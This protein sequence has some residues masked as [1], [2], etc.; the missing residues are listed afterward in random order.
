MLHN[1]YI[2]FNVI[3]T[4]NCKTMGIVD[5]SY[6]NP[7]M[8]VTGYT[9]QVLVPGYDDAV[10]LSYYPSAVTILNSNLLGITKVYDYDD[11]LDLPDGVYT[12]KLSI[13]PYD[14]FWKETSFYRTCKLECKYSQALLSLDFSNC[15]DCFSTSKVNKLKEAKIF[16]EGVKANMTDC[17]FKKATELYQKADSILDNI[18]NCDCE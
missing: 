10:E 5:T 12:I 16:I 15:T 11:M 9:L 17:N 7:S 14:Q 4:F 3:D 18:L 1:T 13:C 2:N 8:T 6:Y